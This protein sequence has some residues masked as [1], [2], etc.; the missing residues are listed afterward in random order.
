MTRRD[1]AVALDTAGV[2]NRMLFGG[3][4]VRQPVFS[5]ARKTGSPA[6]RIIGDLSG[7]DVI[8]NECL[9]V[10]VYPGMTPNMCEHV[11]YAVKQSVGH[12]GRR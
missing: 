3:N 12:G 8:M 1:L 2:G 5:Q 4:L 10:G 6:I 9:F 11:A 7:A